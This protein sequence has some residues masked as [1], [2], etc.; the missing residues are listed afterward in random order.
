MIMLAVITHK[1]GTN[2]IRRGGSRHG[3][4]GQSP[5][6]RSPLRLPR[7]RRP[8]GHP[9]RRRVQDD[10]SPGFT[11]HLLVG[12]DLIFVCATS[13]DASLHVAF[14]CLAQVKQRFLLG[15]LPVRAQVAEQHELDRDFGSVAAE[16]M[17]RC[18]E[19]QT[20]DQISVLNRQVED[21]K[22]IMAQNIEKV[23]ERG[24]RLDSLLEKTQDL[25]QAGTAF[26]ATAKKVNRHMCLR[27]ARMTIIIGVIVVGVITLIVLFATG[28]IKT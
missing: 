19:G 4:T 2:R 15:S 27:N 24:D 20:G 7:G 14:Q 28:V 18:N 22:G 6:D 21:V 25:E 3:G 23:V 11:F 10:A 12:G 5:G 1:Y 26:R 17:S 9:G 16:I 8:A 13:P